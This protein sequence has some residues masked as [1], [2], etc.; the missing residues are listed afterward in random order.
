MHF[1]CCSQLSDIQ[2]TAAAGFHYVELRGKEVEALSE[3]EFND[4]LSVFSESGLECIGFNAYCPKEIVIAGPGYDRDNTRRYASIVAERAAK[5]G[6]ARVCI[7]SPFSRTLPDGYDRSRA[8]EECI[9][10]LSDTAEF[11]DP[12]QVKV[13]M[14]AL[15]DC[16]C[17]FINTCDEALEVIRA[18]TDHKIWLNLDF[19]NMQAQGEADRDLSDLAPFIS[20]V[21][22]SDDVDGDGWRKFAIKPERFEIHKERMERLRGI[23]YDGTVSLETDLPL[24]EQPLAE[25]LELMKKL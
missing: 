17:N 25:T 9:Q 3:K 8:K 10:F 7:G 16:F 4:F 19:Y 11:M 14:E 20:N 22:I 12:A 1:A 15:A 23:G 21:H 2:H 6:A 24:S 18:V 13:G 5:L